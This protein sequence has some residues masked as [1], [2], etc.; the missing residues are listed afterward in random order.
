[1]NRAIPADRIGS[2]WYQPVRDMIT[3]PTITARD[4]TAS[5]ATSA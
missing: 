1:M 3:A 2:R 4:D 5:T